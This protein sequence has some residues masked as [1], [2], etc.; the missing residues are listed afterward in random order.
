MCHFYLIRVSFNFPFVIKVHDQPF[1]C[2]ILKSNIG[3]YL[4]A[5]FKK[6]KGIPRVQKQI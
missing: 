6:T 2:E 3:Q 4:A 1:N 5:T